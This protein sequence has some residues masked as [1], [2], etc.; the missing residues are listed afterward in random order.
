MQF[1]FDIL[2]KMNNLIIQYNIKTKG[3]CYNSN[4]FTKTKYNDINN[5]LKK[6]SKQKFKI[7]FHVLMN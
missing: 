5:V 6:S 3:F 1:F 7:F 4:K 2:K